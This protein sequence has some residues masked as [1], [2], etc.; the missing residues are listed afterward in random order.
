MQMSCF[1]TQSSINNAH[2]STRLSTDDNADRVGDDRGDHDQSTNSH[3][4]QREKRRVRGDRGGELSEDYSE[5]HNN[6]DTKKVTTSFR[7]AK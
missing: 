3:H 2:V 5:I 6:L 1:H 4:K 7:R